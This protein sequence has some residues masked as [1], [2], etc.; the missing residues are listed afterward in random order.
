MRVEST[1]GE[2]STFELWLPEYRGGIGMEEAAAGSRSGVGVAGAPSRVLTVLVAED[3]AVVRAIARRCL[4]SAGHRVLLASSGDEALDVAARFAGPIDVLLSDVVMPGMRG[5]EL[6][7]RLRVVRPGIRVVLASGFAEDE[8]TRRAITASAEAF[9]PKP[10][11][12]ET[13][14]AAVQA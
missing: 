11:S 9:L 2:G 6:A 4:V 8:E 14:L 1:V 3:E 13:L 10:Y 7:E 12:M 5:P